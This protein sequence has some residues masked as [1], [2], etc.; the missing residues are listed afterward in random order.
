MV[1]HE[2]EKKNTRRK[3][4]EMFS[5]FLTLSYSLSKAY[6]SYSSDR[7]NKEEKAAKKKL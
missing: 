7:L 1:T 3:L 6:L 5:V 4:I 2:E